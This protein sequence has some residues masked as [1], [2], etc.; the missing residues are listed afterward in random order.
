M[1]I[2]T[3]QV[4]KKAVHNLRQDREVE[5]RCEAFTAR[6]EHR[7]CALEVEMDDKVSR[8][9]LAREVRSAQSG[10]IKRLVLQEIENRT[11]EQVAALVKEEVNRAVHQQS[12]IIFN[13]EERNEATP[14]VQ[15]AA[16]RDTVNTLT[17]EHLGLG[18]LAITGVTR[19]GAKRGDRP[20]PLKVA[21][22]SEDDRI[23]VLRA[24]KKLMNAPDPYNKFSL[25]PDNVFNPL[26]T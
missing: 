25:K 7:V 17:S 2:G 18:N 24:A 9:D 23:E 14:E 21:M 11:Q 5:E 4:E 16:D 10:E 12:D 1:Y 8:E 3:V 26:T 6:M 22:S 19:L 20:R 13:M 15:R